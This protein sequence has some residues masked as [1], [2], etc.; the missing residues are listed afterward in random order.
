MKQNLKEIKI[1][2]KTSSI[3]ACD[4]G[5]DHSPLGTGDLH[6]LLLKLVPSYLC[7]GALKLATS[8]NKLCCEPLPLHNP[9]TSQS[10]GPDELAWILEAKLQELIMLGTCF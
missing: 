8:R 10:D 5:T 2:K 3:R 4:M 6:T 9:L 1:C 7:I